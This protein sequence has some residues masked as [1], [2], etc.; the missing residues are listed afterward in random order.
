MEVKRIVV[1]KKVYKLQHPGNREWLQVKETMYKPQTDT[2][3]M[4]P[5][6]DYCFEHVVFPEEGNKIN[7]DT[8]DPLDLEVWQEI[9]PRFFR[10]L[11]ARDYI[12]PEDKASQKAGRKLLEG[13]SKK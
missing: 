6:L 4:I 2:I 9:L 13:K 1:N 8:C 11:L 3:V 7:L 10:G 12:Y 5:F